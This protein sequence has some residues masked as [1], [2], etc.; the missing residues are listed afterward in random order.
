[1]NNKDVGAKVSIRMIHIDKLKREKVMLEER[2]EDIN[3]VLKEV[4]N[5]R[6]LEILIEKLNKLGY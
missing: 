1:M 6:E 5:H 3:F 2:L 4:E